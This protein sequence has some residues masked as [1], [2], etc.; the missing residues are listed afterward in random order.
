M[1]RNAKG[2]RKKRQGHGDGASANLAIERPTTLRS[3]VYLHGKPESSFFAKARTCTIT[4]ASRATVSAPVPA[5]RPTAD[6]TSSTEDSS[7][8]TSVICSFSCPSSAAVLKHAGRKAP[9][10]VGRAA[11]QHRAG[12]EAVTIASTSKPCSATASLDGKDRG[13][14]ERASY[15]FDDESSSKRAEV[16]SNM[17]S[18]PVPKPCVSGVKPSRGISTAPCGSGGTWRSGRDEG[19]DFLPGR[20]PASSCRLD[21]E[22]VLLDGMLHDPRVKAWVEQSLGLP[23]ANKKRLP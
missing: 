21:G 3:L 12:G 17:G 13:S 22:L 5:S 20:A 1:H 4:A 10:V 6:P 23:T 16:D 7:D 11:V 8:S 19:V 15:F 18:V 9:P 14:I 2:G